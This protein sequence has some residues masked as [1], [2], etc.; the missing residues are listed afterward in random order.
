MVFVSV[1]II[2]PL[3]LLKNLGKRINISKNTFVACYVTFKIRLVAIQ[4]TVEL[5]QKMFI[6]NNVKEKH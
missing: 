6:V 4:H 5:P 3:S 1:G 2:L